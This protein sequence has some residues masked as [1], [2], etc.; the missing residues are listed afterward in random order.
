MTEAKAKADRIAHN[1]TRL[2]AV[3]ECAARLFGRDQKGRDFF[4]RGVAP[5]VVQADTISDLT[6]AYARIAR[7]TPQIRP[8]SAV[9]A[10]PGH[11]PPSKPSAP[12]GGLFAGLPEGGA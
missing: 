5:K 9:D 3:R 4:A 1:L 12:L 8:A 10:L 11:N 7:Q 6:A 2:I